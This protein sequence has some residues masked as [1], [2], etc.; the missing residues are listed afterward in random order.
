MGN[1]Y[2]KWAFSEAA[3]HVAEWNE[4]VDRLLKKLEARHG[5]GKGKS[6][7]AHKLGRAV[8]HMLR[9][10]TVFD[11]AKFLSLPKNQSITPS[12]AKVMEPTAIII[13]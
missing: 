7:L 13:D 11:E 9:Q 12:G 6:L 1:P 8:Y 2:L 4:P 3:V 5:K 10:G